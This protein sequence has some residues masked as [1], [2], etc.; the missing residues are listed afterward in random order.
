METAYAACQAKV[1]SNCNTLEEYMKE[2]VPSDEPEFMPKVV[3]KRPMGDK[4]YFW[5]R[6]PD[7]MCARRLRGQRRAGQGVQA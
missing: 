5:R 1:V 6:D 7:D 3:L 4:G 2:G